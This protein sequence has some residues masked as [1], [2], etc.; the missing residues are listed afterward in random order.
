[1]LQKTG[2]SVEEALD[3]FRAEGGWEPCQNVPQNSKFPPSR[4][5]N[6]CGRCLEYR[7]STRVDLSK[8][9][10]VWLCEGCRGPNPPIIV[11]QPESSSYSDFI[12]AFRK[13]L[14]AK[15]KEEKKRER[16]ERKARERRLPRLR[17]NG[18]KK[19]KPADVESEGP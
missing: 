12:K 18:S 5:V 6:Q 14:K 10:R 17:R 8:Y 9:Q 1:M 16:E 7:Q 15:E 4:F 2:I 3:W 19:G 13:D 11:P